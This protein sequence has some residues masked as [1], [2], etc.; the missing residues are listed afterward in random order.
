MMASIAN[1]RSSARA[2]GHSTAAMLMAFPAACFIGAFITDIV[3]WRTAAV[4]WETMS[5]WLLV[6]GLVTSAFAV[7]AV[8]IVLLAGRRRGDAKIGWFGALGNTLA[9]VL[10]ILNAFIHSRDGYTAVVPTGITLS[11]IV[12]LILLL[13]GWMGQDLF[14]G[15]RAQGVG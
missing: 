7:L 4:M 9:I 14:T 3:Y 1:A 13:T 12:V 5:I 10:S 11:G 8:G 2:G 15:R 6:A